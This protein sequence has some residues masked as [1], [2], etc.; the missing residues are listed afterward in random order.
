VRIA[1]TPV[2]P[3]KLLE[4]IAGGSTGGGH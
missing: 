4:L 2:S 1:Q 3:Q